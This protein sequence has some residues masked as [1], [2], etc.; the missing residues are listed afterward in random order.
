MKLSFWGA[1]QTVTGSMHELKVQGRRYLLDCGLYQG[2]RADARNR[3]ASFPFP[4]SSVDGVILS[5]AHIDHSGNLPTLVKNG[6]EGPIYTTPATVDLCAAM[7]PDS[8]HVQEKDAL[9]LAKRKDRRR[10]LGEQDPSE[11]VEPLYS[12]D[13]AEA[14]IPLMKGIQLGD[15]FEPGPGLVCKTYDAGHMLGSTCIYMDIEDNGK[16]HSLVFS[17]DVGRKNLPIIR[18]PQ[19]VPPAEYL[20][21]ESTYGDRLHQQS[22]GV[23]DK[24]ADVINRTAQ[25]GGRVICPA[26]AVGRTQ[27][28]VLVLNQLMESGRIAPIPVFVDSPLAV[29]VTETFQ[30]RTEHYDEETAGFVWN[31][32]EPFSFPQLRYIKEVSES[33]ALN[34]L[35]SPCIIIS[36]SGMCE[37]GR[38]LHHLKNNIENPRNTVLITGFQA[39]HTL[40]R[41]IVDKQPEVNIFGEPLRLRAEVVKMNELSGHA[42]QSELLAWI[43][44]ISPKLKKIFLVHGEPKQSQALAQAI[45]NVYGIETVIPA[46]GESATL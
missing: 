20:I 17:G 28:L 1:A 31:G 6:F 42:D 14:T 27:Q 34:D 11:I 44:P 32:R 26:F 21:M 13:D 37:F 3:N 10:S 23:E 24:L 9:F 4:A 25:R 46:R 18:D 36:A 33:K 16:R 7:L 29:K 40:G 12:M 5:H 2:R 35:R 41:K 19:D 15:Y 22:S 43:K 39:E 30:N 38:I 45:R 8:A